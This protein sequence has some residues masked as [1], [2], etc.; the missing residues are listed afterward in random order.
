MNRARWHQTTFLILAAA[1][2]LGFASAG[3]TAAHAAQ[4]NAESTGKNDIQREVLHELR[5]LNYYTVFDNLGYSVDG[6]HVTLSGEVTNPTLKSDA[7]NSVKK[8]AGV[9]DV[10]DNIRVLP[11]SP[12]DDSI[13]RAEYRAIYGDPQLSKYGFAS[14]Q[15]IHIIVDHGHVTLEGSV[16]TQADKDVA[17][18]R[19]SGVPN[20]FSVTNNLMVNGEH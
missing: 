11:L 2:A 20:A 9:T 12:D 3:R 8:I 16:D 15:S 4:K 1:V 13:R 6:G 17:N 5:M 19:A 18:I 14:V 7:V 10:T